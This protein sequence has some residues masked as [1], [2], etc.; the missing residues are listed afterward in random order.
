MR[1]LPQ[2]YIG[3]S[4][5]S[6]AKEWKPSLRYNHI[7]FKESLSSHLHKGEVKYWQTLAINSH[8]SPNIQGTPPLE[9]AYTVVLRTLHL[10]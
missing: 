7:T 9:T 10:L 8:S 4:G 3:G 5:V 6:P 1:D 2:G